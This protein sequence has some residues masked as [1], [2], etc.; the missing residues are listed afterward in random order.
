MKVIFTDGDGDSQ[1]RRAELILPASSPP[2]DGEYVLHMFR[3]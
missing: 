3:T 2:V 1:Y